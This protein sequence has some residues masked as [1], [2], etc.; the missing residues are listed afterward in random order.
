MCLAGN[1]GAC[2]GE[3]VVV[4]LDLLRPGMQVDP[5]YATLQKEYD[6]LQAKNARLESKLKTTEQK[7]EESIQ[8]NH[9]LIKRLSADNAKLKTTITDQYDKIAAL[10]DMGARL[11]RNKL[12]LKVQ[13]HDQNISNENKDAQITSLQDDIRYKDTQINSLKDSIASLKHKIEEYAEAEKNAWQFG[14]SRQH[15]VIQSDV[16]DWN[17]SFAEHAFH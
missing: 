8:S 9:D 10:E 12:E 7:F 16:I 1:F 5:E 15:E 3:A 17:R 6:E 14:F 13:L 11:R 4:I 2:D